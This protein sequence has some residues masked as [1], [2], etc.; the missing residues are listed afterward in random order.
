MINRKKYKLKE[1]KSKSNVN[2]DTFVK[3]NLF[4]ENRMLP[5]GEINHVIDVAEQF[6]KERQ[7]SGLYRF[8][9]TINPLFSN[10]LFNPDTNGEWG[11]FGSNI[12]P[13]SG[14]A[15]E[16]F[17]DDIFKKEPKDNDFDDLNY[18]Y[19]E[20]INKHLTEVNG[21]FGFYDPDVTSPTTCAYFDMEPTRARFDLNKSIA[22]NW[23]VLIT[24]PASVNDTH[25]II[26][27]G[28]LLVDANAVE[29]G[30]RDMVALAT[31]TYHNLRIGD[32]VLL[33]G[34]GD[35]ALNGTFKVERTGLDN[36]DFKNNY[37]VID[38]NP[39]NASGSL[40]GTFGGGRMKRNYNGKLSRYYIRQFKNIMLDKNNYEIYPLA[41][42]K[43]IFND[44]NYQISITEDIDVGGLTDNL[45]RP[46]SEL[47]LTF[48]KKDSGVFGNVQSGFDLELIEGSLTNTDLS[49]VRRMHDGTT[50]PVP[51]HPPLPGETA[52]NSSMN[53]FYGDVVEYNEYEQKEFVLSDVLHR[54][55]TINRETSGPTPPASGPRREG[56]L[57]KPHHKIKIREFS[58]YI[59]Q[60]DQ[61]TAGIPDYATDLGDGRYLW[62]DLL[63]IGIFDGEGDFLDYPFTNGVHYIHS[64]IC[65]KTT[66]QDPFGNYGL[67]YSG[68]DEDDGNFDPPDP[69]GDAITNRFVVKRSDDVC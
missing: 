34:I 39:S 64:N 47:Y 27:G 15:W 50:L 56:Y 20:A 13:K 33:S 45:G 9:F 22:D 32:K 23:G 66:R 41:F 61:F 1:F 38:V 67:Y 10:P 3:V 5:P 6:N 68:N 37:F 18:N 62:R 49:N 21:W 24:Y 14:N 51:T 16:T 54:F 7:E 63:D 57:Y 12:K 69:R 19:P 60:G 11:D 2:Q 28:L 58:L 53:L 55:N 31:A 46:L 26:N 17:D 29:V 4:E 25:N 8:I 40:G 43:T 59:E 30:G 65:L 42:S 36:G 44:Q 48:I 52:I 35:N